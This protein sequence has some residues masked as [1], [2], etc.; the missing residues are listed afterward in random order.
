MIKKIS[1]ALALLVLILLSYVIFLL[2]INDYKDNFENIISKKANIELTIGG[3]L[4]LDLGI[5]TNISA[6]KLKIKKIIFC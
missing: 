5:N 3:D 4:N 6:E 1:L 2:D